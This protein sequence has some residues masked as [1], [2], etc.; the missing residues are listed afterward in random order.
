M[1]GDGDATMEEF[2]NAPD[3]LVRRLPP[4]LT[5]VRRVAFLSLAPT[6]ACLAAPLALALFPACLAAGPAPGQPVPT[7][8]RPVVDTYH[9]ET[10]TDDYRWLENW[11]DPEVQAWSEA[12]NTRAR[13]F[14]DAIPGRPE[15]ARRMAEL[16]SFE[17]VSYRGLVERGGRIFAEERKPPREQPLLV[18]LASAAAPGSAH[19]VCDPLALDSTG[20]TSI[21][22]FV[23][24]PDGKR[25]AV[26][27]SQGGSE[28]GSVRVFDAETG[29]EL[30]GGPVP[31]ANTGTASGSL[32][33]AADGGSFWYTRHPGADEVKDADLGFFQVIYRHV[34]GSPAAGD[35]PSLTEGLPRTAESSLEATDDGR[36]VSDLVQ[37]GDGGDY[38][39]FLLDTAKETWTKVARYEDGVTAARFGLDDGLWISERG[40]QG[41]G[42]IL[43]LEPGA[44]DLASALTV[45]PE[46]AAIIGSFEVTNDRLWVVEQ[47][48]GPSHL[49]RYDIRGNDLGEAP[50]PPVS[51]VYGLTRTAGGAIIFH[52]EGYTKPGGWWLAMPDG[53]VKPTALRETSPASLDAVQVVRLEA[54]SKDGTRVPMTVL[55]PPGVKKDGTAPALLTGYGGFGISAAPGFSRERI[56]WLEQGCVWAEANLRGG[57]EFGEAWHLAGNLTR[58]QNVFDDFVACAEKLVADGYT[59]PGRLAIQGGSNGGLLV[60]AALTQRPDLFRAVVAEVG[61]YDMLRYETRPNGQFNN[62]EYGTVENADQYRALRAY[63]PYHAVKDGVR[64]PPTLFLT[65]ANDPRVDP[66]HSRKMVARLQAVGS[67]AWLRTSGSTGHGIGTPLSERIAESVDVHSFLDAMLMV[68]AGHGGGGSR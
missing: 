30:P 22:W 54:I 61:Y 39:L 20:R 44:T 66:F 62:T 32:A 9:G 23:P 2:M 52:L 24:S 27:L 68:H 11:D 13:A 38:E 21:D 49:R 35:T 1:L 19:A 67:E 55:V 57:A 47:A 4:A 65:G 8:R 56:A 60:G 42:R 40:E 33:W 15:V 25:V 50:A 7:I 16:L 36:F 28:V 29:R 37:L 41:R 51:S 59:N 14:L 48:G 58:K 63:S 18:A 17:S 53:A 64:Y 45:V 3:V 5:L 10:V 6:L 12:Q 26:S 31:R 34:V 43:R 46:G